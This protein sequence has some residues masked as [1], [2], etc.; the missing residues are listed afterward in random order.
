M[1]KEA[2]KLAR[3]VVKVPTERIP[4]PLFER[5]ERRSS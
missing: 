5:K 1:R 3:E 4:V 2:G